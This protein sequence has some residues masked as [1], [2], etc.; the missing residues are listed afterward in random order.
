MANLMIRFGLASFNSSVFNSSMLVPSSAFYYLLAVFIWKLLAKDMVK[1]K[2]PLIISVILGLLVSITKMDEFHTGYGA[3]FSLF[4]FFVMG[5]LCE[6]EM[7]QKIRD[8]PKVIAVF[9]LILGIIPAVYLPYAI[10]SVRMSYSAVGFGNV[11]GIFYRI[12]FYVIATIM[13]M[14]FIC[15]MSDKKMWISHI[16][17]ASILV[18]AGS[19][20]LSPHAYVLLDK[21]LSLSSNE[22]VNLICMSVFCLVVIVI[23]SLPLFL[24][25]Y[26][27][28][29][30][31]INKLLFKRIDE[32]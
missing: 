17:K 30:E 12:I 31:F 20:F 29:L 23:C 15:L 22:V 3:I 28:I 5:L 19:T 1:L 18:Y 14:A 25:L 4:P 11:I 2:Y 21:L 24:T 6:K 32:K 27:S 9:A 7:I 16:G 26:N 8:I 13:G 10:H